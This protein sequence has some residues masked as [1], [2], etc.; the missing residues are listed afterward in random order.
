MNK[1]KKKRFLTTKSKIKMSQLPAEEK[2]KY[3]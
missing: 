3:F 2:Q 1:T